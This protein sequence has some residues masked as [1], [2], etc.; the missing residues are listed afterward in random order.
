MSINVGEV[1]A[2][3]GTTIVLKI[4]DESNKRVIFYNSHKLQ[5]I[6]I[7]RHIMI[8]SGFIDII[9]IVENEY[10]EESRNP[11]QNKESNYIRKVEVKPIGY[12]NNDKMNFGIKYLPMIKDPVYL[13]SD[14]DIDNIYTQNN[15]CDKYYKEF[16]IGN[17]LTEEIPISLPWDKLFNT[18][19]G[20]FGN[21]GS[22]KSNTLTKLY[23]TLF[24]QKSE[25]IKNK[26]QFIIIDFNGEY[27]KENCLTEKNN[28]T[29]YK[30]VTNEKK[31]QDDK[32]PIPFD[33]II[34]VDIIALLFQA[35]PTTQKPFIKRTIDG[36]KKYETNQS[37]LKNYIKSTIEKMFFTPVTHK[38]EMLELLKKSVEKTN[39]KDKFNDIKWH[40]KNA[41]FYKGAYNY[42]DNSH[43]KLTK[44]E[45]DK[46]ETME[47]ITK[48]DEL[49]IR[50][51]I[52]LIRDLLQG[53]VQYDH[54]QPLLKR[55]ESTSSDLTKILHIY[56]GNQDKQTNKDKYLTIV[57]LKKCNQTIKKTIP[58]IIA[59]YLYDTHKNNLEDES[60]DKTIHLIIDEAHNILSE[61]SNRE[62]ETFKDY[63]LEVFEEIIKEGRK[64]N[65]FLTI[66]SQR[67]A[68]ISP[69]IMSQLHNFFIHRLVNDKDL[70]MLNNTISFLD[71]LSKS[72]IPHLAKG[73]CIATGTAFD[74]PLVL[75][76]DELESEKKP[77]SDDANLSELW[78]V[79]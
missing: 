50:I 38:K 34:D 25:G 42:N 40:D 39:F 22:G 63:R 6:S 13:L 74:I 32:Y 2:V 77:D 78:G 36:W 27:I 10:L 4:F 15:K 14:K 67:P 17:L 57:S 16:R 24:T 45:L 18:H 20:I 3:K 31:A 70:N 29:E 52:Q 48:F 71:T 62:P 58:L 12:K 73:S 5:G 28:K 49:I 75:Q 30:L 11:K 66:C 64:F 56:D 33:S 7:R 35:T 53:F 69:T 72:M 68:D 51:Y 79:Q 54:I 55:I 46:I 37:S 41:L 47:Y 1:F 21:T 19:I 26:S 8:Q 61:Q 43:I 60:K 9:C 76:I 23:T 44:D 59:K 65:F